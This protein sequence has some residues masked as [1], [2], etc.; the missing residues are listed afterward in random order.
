MKALRGQEHQRYRDG[1]MK[2]LL[3]KVPRNFDELSAVFENLGH[4]AWEST[5]WRPRMTG[6]IS[7]SA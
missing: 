1:V 4:I 6:K 5:G 2:A 7:R 3:E